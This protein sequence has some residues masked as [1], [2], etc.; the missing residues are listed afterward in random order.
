MPALRAVHPDSS[1]TPAAA[2]PP[3]R[4]QHCTFF[5]LRR[6]LMPDSSA[7]LRGQRVSQGAASAGSLWPPEEQPQL[8]RLAAASF[9]PPHPTQRASHQ[10]ARA[11]C[12]ST[13]TSL[14]RPAAG[15]A[16]HSAF[17]VSNRTHCLGGG[18]GAG[19]C[20]EL[21]GG[22][23][24]DRPSGASRPPPSP[25]LADPRP[26]PPRPPICP[27]PTFWAMISP[28]GAGS[29]PT[30]SSCRRTC[31]AGAVEGRGWVG[32]RREVSGR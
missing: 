26:Y 14:G 1:G 7:L 29:S 19:A 16:R 18:Q 28:G 20:A 30:P 13:P 27:Q 6:S 17:I 32:G 24:A 4:P 2:P 10:A 21:G 12:A 23:G 5:S 8:A 15:G 22:K 31:V 9:T 25:A 11:H 3:A